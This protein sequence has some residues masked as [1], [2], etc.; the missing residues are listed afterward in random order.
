[1][2]HIATITLLALASLNANADNTPP[3]P[4]CIKPF[5]PLQF[6]SD[7]DVNNYN[8]QL[9]DYRDCINQFVRQQREQANNHVE[10]AK[11]AVEAYNTF[12][13]YGH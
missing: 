1:M 10:A 3:M 12:V 13:Q 5:K 11:Q 4:T 7:F 9:R 2:K 6:N 8:Q